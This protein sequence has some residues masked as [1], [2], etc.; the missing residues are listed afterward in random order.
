MFSTF[1]IKKHQYFEEKRMS[2]EKELS[3]RDFMKSAAAG[4]V[5]I[6]TLSIAGC[7]PHTSTPT[8][9][10]VTTAPEATA[11]PEA[12]QAPAESADNITIAETMDCELVVI[13][14]GGGG[15]MTASQAVRKG[16]KT[17]VVEKNQNCL[18]SNMNMVGGTTACNSQ[19]QKKEN[20]N[21]DVSA[22][23][24][25][26]MKYAE[27]TVNGRLVR[28]YLEESAA[29]MDYWTS[30]GMEFF[31]GPDRYESG[32]QTVHVYL[33]PN[34]MS[35]LE[36]DIKD[37]DGQILYSC[38][39][40]KIVMTDGK[41]TG[42]VAQKADGSYV[43]I[44]A[45][46]VC[47]ATG[48]FLYND[49]MMKQY[50][51]DAELV[52]R[53]IGMPSSTGDGINMG[54]AAGC[55]MDTNFALST[56]ADV[57]GY[58]EKNANIM[59]YVMGPRNAGFI[60]GNT[61]SMLVDNQGRRFIN[62]Y[63]LSVNPLAYGGAI[64]ARTGYYYAIVDQALVD[65]YS[66]KTPY[67]RVGRTGWNVGPILFDKVPEDINGDIA[68]AISEGWAFKADSIEEL[69]KA[70][71]LTDLV[72]EVTNYNSYV[73]AGVDKD[74]SCNPKFMAAVKTGPFYAFEYQC[75][76]LVTMGGLK[77]DWR[78]RALDKDNKVIEGLWVASS[79]NGSAF[80]GPYYD[81]GGSSSGLASA[82]GWIA[83]EEIAAF[84]GK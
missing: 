19:A 12:T 49:E 52:G 27:G 29:M 59:K 80:N 10:P 47:I 69:A 77:T 4:T 82:T 46:S 33:T 31:M 56:L 11:A 38:P 74:L 25:H 7:A 50:F 43:Q 34:K 48:G 9:A 35:L 13:G 3:R 58:N 39:A 14:G 79:D 57:A 45:K 23:H 36:K 81:I 53:K 70:T 55:I 24:A 28:R 64:Q 75:G 41:A 83:G 78:C 2:M 44:N 60:F 61:G 5:G 68:T 84:L 8:D 71:G 6:A 72:E 40:K 18:M 65:Y 54:L 67:D 51:G 62:E 66:K 76:G 30:L 37:H 26:M 20:I 17:I 32:F 63:E 73:D 42:V 15:F 1:L 21:I 16:V 22:I